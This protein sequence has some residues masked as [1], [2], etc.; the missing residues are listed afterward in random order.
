M[1]EWFGGFGALDGTRMAPGS[2]GEAPFLFSSGLHMGVD[3]YS[4]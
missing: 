1:N 3:Q 4:I 2:G